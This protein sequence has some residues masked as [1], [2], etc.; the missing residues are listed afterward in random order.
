MADPYAHGSFLIPRAAGL[1]LIYFD[2]VLSETVDRDAET[3]EFPVEVGANITDHYRIK[4]TGMRLEVFCS[5]EPINDFTHPEGAPF[6][7]PMALSFT[8]HPY[9]SPGLLATLGTALINPVGLL[10]SGLSNALGGDP[11][12]QNFG[13]VLQFGTQFDALNTLLTALDA[14][15]ANPD[16]PLV[17]VYTRAQVYDSMVIGKV[18]TNRDKETGTGAK[19]TIEFKRIATVQTQTTGAPAIPAKPKDKAPVSK[20]A[21]Q[22]Q[23]PGQMQSLASA[24]VGGLKTGLGF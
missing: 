2:A 9:P 21:Q 4:L 6:R 12:A 11:R 20:G 15:R 1:G 22:P 5:N 18:T 8:D 23:D 10:T 13:P 14:I 3:T 17:D 19:V 24:L 7:G 16:T